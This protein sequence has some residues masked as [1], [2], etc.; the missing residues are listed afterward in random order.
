MIEIR[1]IHACTSHQRSAFRLSGLFTVRNTVIAVLSLVVFTLA[2]WE[3]STVAYWKPE[4]NAPVRK[5]LWAAFLISESCGQSA[6][7]TPPASFSR[8]SFKVHL[9]PVLWWGLGRWGTSPSKKTRFINTV[10]LCKMDGLCP[11]HRQKQTQ[12]PFSGPQDIIS[13]SFWNWKTWK[14]KFFPWPCYCGRESFIT[15]YWRGGGGVRLCAFK[16][17]WGSAIQC[18]LVF[19]KYYYYC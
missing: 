14:Q 16:S 15:W 7:M 8:L 3:C 13:A 11:W 10:T 2:S 18:L 12:N 4:L 6:C 1:E 19:Y 17:M 9:H 5:Y